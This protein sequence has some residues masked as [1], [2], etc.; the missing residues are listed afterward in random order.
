MSLS[1]LLAG[2]RSIE[3]TT[4]KSC[5]EWLGVARR[6]F[7][8]INQESDVSKIINEN[9]FPASILVGSVTLSVTLLVLGVWKLAELTTLIGW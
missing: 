7:D 2:L 9:W 4:L 5:S 1:V 6:F 8:S 3:P